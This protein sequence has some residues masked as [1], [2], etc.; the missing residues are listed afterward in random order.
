MNKCDNVGRSPMSLNQDSPMHS[1]VY[2]GY[3]YKSL[4]GSDPHG[5]YID[6]SN[7]LRLYSL[8]ADWELCS[9]TLDARHV[10]STYP[11]ATVTLVLADGSSFCTSLKGYFEEGH[12]GPGKDYIKYKNIQ[13]KYGLIVRMELELSWDCCD[14]RCGCCGGSS[15]EWRPDFLI[16][17]RMM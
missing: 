2:N 12:F 15:F 13:S 16:R 8:D 4:A 1:V 10:C 3:M 5:S 14:S 11:W 9:P 7:N 6:F 17:R